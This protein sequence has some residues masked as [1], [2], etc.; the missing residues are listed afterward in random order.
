MK[1]TIPP[2]K[3][4]EPININID[5][6]NKITV[7][8]LTSPEGQKKVINRIAE[9]FAYAIGITKGVNKEIE[10]L[11][12]Q[13]RLYEWSK[14]YPKPTFP[15]TPPQLLRRGSAESKVLGNA[16]KELYKTQMYDSELFDAFIRGTQENK[17]QQ[18]RETKERNESQKTET[19][20]TMPT[21][22]AD[23]K[24]TYSLREEEK[25][26]NAEYIYEYLKARGWTTQA[27]C[28]LL[29]NIERESHLNPA[30]YEIPN[31]VNRGYGLVQW[32]S[33]EDFFEEV[34]VDKKIIDDM[35][36][37]N[38]QSLMDLQL[39]FIVDTSLPSADNSIKRWY[40]SLVGNRDTPYI[41]EFNEYINSTK[42]PR[43]LAK[44]FNSH[45]E[46]SDDDAVQLKERAD[47]AEK[48]YHYFNERE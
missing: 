32:T 48:W 16:L 36:L 9:Q 38:P 22:Y 33:A 20:S 2:L 8:D 40:P 29:G 13:Q 39:D 6:H 37:E 30:S 24:D 5:M 35:A 19:S 45:Y 31:N 10:K 41:M 11:E 18:K 26:S 21:V 42:N 14:L 23:P 25:I 7:S 46:R 43:D 15:A 34:G 12:Q 1:I 44:V 17:E 3:K 47:N 27:I 4:G 28:G